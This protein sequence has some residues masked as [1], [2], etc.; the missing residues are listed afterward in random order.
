[1]NVASAVATGAADTGMGIRAAAEALGLDFIPVA[2]ERY[3]LIVPVEMED[4]PKL[5]Q[6]FTVITQDQEFRDIVGKLGGYDLQDSG[7]VFYTQ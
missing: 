2:R 7:K 5:R 1:M 4:D 6:L 3:D